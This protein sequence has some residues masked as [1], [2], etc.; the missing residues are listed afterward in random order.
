[1]MQHAWDG[2]KRYA[3]GG[4]ELDSVHN[5]RRGGIFGIHEMGATIVDSLDTLFL[6]DMKE[7]L[8]EATSWVTEHLSFDKV[9]VRSDSSD[10]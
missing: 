9:S 3:W 5:G 2:Y 7:E 6:M 4:N 8:R 1:M 10:L